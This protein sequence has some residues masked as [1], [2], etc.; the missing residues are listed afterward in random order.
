MEDRGFWELLPPAAFPPSKYVPAGRA[1]H[2]SVIKGDSIW[3]FGGESF[4]QTAF[5]VKYDINGE[6]ISGPLRL[7]GRGR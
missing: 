1:S 3:L 5:V 6:W 4:T 7:G 2:A